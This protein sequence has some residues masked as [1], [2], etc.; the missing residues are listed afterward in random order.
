[1]RT[2]GLILENIEGFDVDPISGDLVNPPFFRA[3]PSLFNLEF[4]APYGYSGCCP[5]LQDFAMGAVIQH[6]TKTLNRLVTVDFV[7]PTDAQLAAM[8]AFMLS[9]FSPAD[10]NFKVKGKNS[11]LSTDADT[12][13]VDTSRAQ[14]RGR[15]LFLSVGCTSCHSANGKTV[16]NGGFRNTGVESLEVGFGSTPTVDNGN[17]VGQFLTPQLFGMRKQHFFHT[18]A[19]GT[20][21]DAVAFYNSNEFSIADGLGDD[22][23]GLNMT[24]LEIDDITAFLEAISVE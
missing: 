9:I 11:L 8:E 4:T 16:F 24:D 10:G 15:E 18:G 17:G 5:N 6:L 21:R 14:V 23:G 19:V 1:M 20:L 3:V 22:A 12:R 7:L 2:R 13:A